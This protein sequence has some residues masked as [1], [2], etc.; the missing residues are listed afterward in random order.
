LTKTPRVSKVL[1]G[2]DRQPGAFDRERAVGEAQVV[3]ERAA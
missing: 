2:C 1:I 3:D